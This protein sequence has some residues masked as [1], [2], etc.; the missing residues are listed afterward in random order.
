[1]GPLDDGV[2]PRNAVLGDDGVLSVAGRRVD[3]L[4]AEF[5]SPLFVLDEVGIPP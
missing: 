3:E 2:W 1:M 4:I 5:G